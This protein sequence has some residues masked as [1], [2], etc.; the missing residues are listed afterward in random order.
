M[1]SWE[2]IYC[3]CPGHHFLCWKIKILVNFLAKR[4][5]APRCWRPLIL[6]HLA[7][8]L[9]VWGWMMVL[10]AGF[11]SLDLNWCV[12]YLGHMAAY[13]QHKCQ[14]LQIWSNTVYVRTVYCVPWRNSPAPTPASVLCILQDY[15]C[16]NRYRKWRNSVSVCT[17]SRHRAQRER[18]VGA[19][20]ERV[21]PSHRPDL[22]NEAPPFRFC[23][24]GWFVP[25]TK[26]GWIFLF[27]LLSV[28]VND[29]STL[30][31]CL[32]LLAQ[33]QSRMAPFRSIPVVFSLLLQSL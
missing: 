8:D 29:V 3:R 1:V 12:S 26:A 31:V 20:W 5:E 7:R 16:I 2:R 24:F 11:F 9:S 22:S 32:M 19:G 14:T 15:V 21:F 10:L 30:G 23:V 25:F 13:C 33:T 27:I 6:R 28:D 17:H 18:G 4:S